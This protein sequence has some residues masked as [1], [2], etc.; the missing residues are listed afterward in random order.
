MIRF[1]ITAALLVFC[2]SCQ[3][4]HADAPTVTVSPVIDDD[5]QFSSTPWTFEGNEGVHIQTEYWNIYTTIQYEHIV[6]L[7]PSFYEEL[8]G[9]YATV[10]GQ[11][12]YPNRRMD[13]F[14]FAT[15]SQWRMKVQDMLG[16][17]AEQ[18]FGLGRGG[19]TIEGVAVLY[20]LDRRGRS[21]TTLRIA[22]H[23]GWHQYAEAIFQSELPTWLDEGIGTWMEGFRMRN[24]S[25]Q[26]EP[27]SNW[28][29]LSSLRKLVNAKRL[30]PLTEVMSSNPSA[31][32]SDSRSS[33]LGYYAQLW[34]LTSFLIEAENAVHREQ[35]LN[36]FH[37]ALDGTLKRRRVSPSYWLQ[38][39]TDDV[40]AFEKRCHE[41]IK[42]FVRPG[43]P[44]RS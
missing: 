23:E 13:V 44:W 37:Q 17:D 12:P 33:L 16:R 29:R 20:D 27:T 36:I 18:W 10:F 4:P 31:L 32:L 7:L 43:S 9:H 41:W 21:R 8:V 14:L 30:T 1:A 6:D 28:D 39:F 19:L 38:F 35:L 2:G 11:L 22:A 42:Q 5:I 25:I 15:Q 40:D 26:F 3:N 34:G 24:G